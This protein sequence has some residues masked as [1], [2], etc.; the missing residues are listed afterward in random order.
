MTAPAAASDAAVRH[1]IRLFVGQIATLQR[2]H[3]VAPAAR[4]YTLTPG[5]SFAVLPFDADI[6]D[7][8]HQRHGTG[9]WDDKAGHSLSS[10]DIAFAAR[11]SAVG[12]LA[13]VE[14]DYTGEHGT[15]SAAL[16]IG[17]ATT[18]API[19]LDTAT[20]L[21]RPPAFWPINAALRGLGIKPAP[22]LDEFT[23]F[24]L[25]LWTSNEAIHDGARPVA[26]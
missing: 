5:A 19:T 10:N 22:P 26:S 14:T 18:M 25:R 7:A 21:T 15:Q 24:G 17:G 9:D 13:F 12:P 16:W 1:A 11:A 4:L 2:F 20:A 6:Q 23:V 3:A 8:L